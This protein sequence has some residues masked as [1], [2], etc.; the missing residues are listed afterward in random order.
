MSARD[1]R[2][3]GGDAAP[4]VLGALTPQ[5]HDAFVEHMR[6]C[7][8]C[9]EEVASLQRAADMLPAAAPRV[10]APNRLK[11]R[12]MAQVREEQQARGREARERERRERGSRGWLGV[13]APIAI[14]LAA[15]AVLA[16]AL[17]PGGGNGRPRV[18]RAEV[19]DP[20]ASAL[21]KVLSGR[22]TLTIA[23][24]PQAPAGH[25]YELWIERQG[26]PRP[27]DVLFTVSAAGSATVGVPGVTGGVHRLLVSSEPLGG[28]ASP[29]STPRIVANL[30]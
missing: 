28:S 30:G 29:T 3:C 13:L 4:Y 27:T 23:H 22:A 9:R 2:P 26:P 10:A 1:D 12:V 5:E 6:T 24:M 7:T 21:V 14:G 8:V 11:R 20:G 19:T 25:V 16:I 17:L 15:I 18:I